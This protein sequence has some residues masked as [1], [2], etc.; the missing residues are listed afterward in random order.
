MVIIIIS[1]EI[2]DNS[3][4]YS[5]KKGGKAN[6]K[7]KERGDPSKQGRTGLSRRTGLS[8]KV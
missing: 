2:I 5:K 3:R 7:Q 8:K 1:I 6:K 4:N